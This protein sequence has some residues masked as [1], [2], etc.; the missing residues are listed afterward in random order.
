MLNQDFIES[1]VKFIPFIITIAMV[2]ATEQIFSISDSKPVE[3][4]MH[5]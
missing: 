3:L 4:S 5:V 2:Y 1:T